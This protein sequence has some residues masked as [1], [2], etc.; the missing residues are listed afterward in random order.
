MTVR[1]LSE[2]MAAG[3]SVDTRGTGRFLVKI[4]DVGEGSSAEYTEEALRDAEARRI[5]PAGT[6]MYLDH[7]G[8]GRRG[9][10]GERSIKDLASVLTSDARYDENERAL[11]AESEAMDGYQE[12]LKSLAPHVGLSISATAEVNPPARSGGKPVVSRFL[13]AESVDWVARAGRGGQVLSILESAGVVEEAAVNDRRD[14][15]DRAVRDMYR[16][17]DRDIW[18]SLSD[19]DE[20]TNTAYFYN[21]N[22]LWAQTYEIAADDLSVTLTG[23]RTEV[24]AVTHYVPA[25]GSAGVIESATNQEEGTMPTI[26][27]AELDRLHAQENQ[28]TE[29]IKRAEEAEAK[30]AEAAKA[31]AVAEAHS[32]VSEKVSEAAKDMPEAMR[33]RITQTVQ[34]QV[35]ESLPEN[36][37]ALITKAVQD[38]RAYLAALGESDRITGFGQQVTESAPAKRTHNAFG[39]PIQEV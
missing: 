19:F 16:D 13:A 22:A 39:R 36:V 29:A 11:V 9:P 26:D 6:H 33:T 27:Q 31:K 12:T 4:I 30:L 7:A 14:Q 1:K 8:V 15:I 25:A 35:T 38:E 21:D 32:A 10:H 24:R 5:F 37:D 18:A 34:A 3:M 23:D 17:P 28:L 2:T 20:G